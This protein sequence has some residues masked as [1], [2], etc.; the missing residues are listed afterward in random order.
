MSIISELKEFA[1][2]S[3]AIEIAVGITIGAGFA[4]IV[5]SLVND[6]LMPPLGILVG[7]VDFRNLKITIKQAAGVEPSV[8]LNY[9]MF[10]NTVV[11]FAIVVFAV[12]IVVKTLNTV[13]KVNISQAI[14]DEF[15]GRKLKG[16][17]GKP[18]NKK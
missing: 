2:K 14:R 4:K 13:R 8:T 18:G 17:K 11:D 12:F 15:S 3:N 7:G 6:I 16:G 9:G 5:N 1:S 10:I